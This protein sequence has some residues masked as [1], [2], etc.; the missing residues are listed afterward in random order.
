[1][2]IPVNE[3]N[4]QKFQNIARHLTN[5]VKNDM[6]IMSRR[7]QQLLN[8]VENDEFKEQFIQH[9]RLQLEN[10][11]TVGPNILT[12]QLQRYNPVLARVLHDYWNRVQVN[13]A[14]PLLINFIERYYSYQ[15]CAQIVLN[16]E[17]LR[18]LG[19]DDAVLN[20]QD[21]N[22]EVDEEILDEQIRE[23]AAEIARQPPNR[24]PVVLNLV[25]EESEEVLARQNDDQDNERV[26]L[27]DPQHEWDLE[28]AISFSDEDLLSFED[29]KKEDLAP[30][31]SSRFRNPKR[32]SISRTKMQK[33]IE[34]Q[35]LDFSDSSE[36]ESFENVFTSESE[37]ISTF[38]VDDNEPIEYYSRKHRKQ[39]KQK[40]QKTKN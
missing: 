11:R 20:G 6:P 15:D 13:L 40:R 7:T 17:D 26:L 19:W 38:V 25:D 1:M 36:L 33:S 2:D 8:N 21:E 30:R 14:F 28:R 4:Q 10:K 22:N 39:R 12:Q 35:Y 31:R 18:Q 9:M 37:D 27:D 32:K 24:E 16:A 23:D 29:N 3:T 5:R 34:K